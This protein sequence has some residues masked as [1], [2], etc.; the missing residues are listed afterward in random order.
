MRLSLL[1][2]PPPRAQCFKQ[3]L[4]TDPPSIISPVKQGSYLVAALNRPQTATSS[5]PDNA[6]LFTNPG[7]MG[8]LRLYVRT[9]LPPGESRLLSLAHCVAFFVRLSKSVSDDLYCVQAQ[10]KLAAIKTECASRRMQ[11]MSP[12][13]PCR[14]YLHSRLFCSENEIQ[15]CNYSV[16]LV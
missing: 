10:K 1:P 8:I 2:L 9:S 4:Q 14:I 6:F 13:P 7:N 3:A 16:L 15:W 11:G 12:R 5:T